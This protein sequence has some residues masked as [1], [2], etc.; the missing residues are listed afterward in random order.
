MSFQTPPSYNINTG[1]P[2][3]NAHL[4]RPP[5]SPAPTIPTP[6]FASAT[7]YFSSTGSRKRS[8]PDSAYSAD[9]RETLGQTPGWLQCPTP[10]DRGYGSASASVYGQGTMM[11]N[12]RYTLA[13]GLDTPGLRATAE[14]EQRDWRFGRDGRSRRDD[15]DAV[16]DSY[17]A[18]P[19]LSG[20]LARERNGVARIPSSPNGESSASW[21]GLAF[22]IV[23]KVFTFGTS[24]VKGFYA[25][26][27]TGYNFKHGPLRSALMGQETC[28][29]PLPGAWH[30]DEF[31]GDFEQD[32]PQIPTAGSGTR[33]PS[34][35]RQTD[36][37]SW[38][39]VG[40][41]S[42]VEQSPRRKASSTVLACNNN[43][44]VRPTASR[45][46][47]RRS[48]APL[49]HRQS[50]YTAYS[51]G[52]PAPVTLAPHE[53][54]ASIAPI[55]IHS[56]P[57]SSGSNPSRAHAVKAVN[58][59]A[60]TSGN[61]SLAY[62]S[63]EAGKLLRRREKQDR[64]ADAAIGDMSRKLAELI[65]QGQQALGTKISVEEGGEDG[66]EVEEG[67]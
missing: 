50:S 14:M 52:S 1:L 13:G 54:R 67:W 40:T 55:R 56:R 27:G 12:E 57:S 32:N 48:L 62:V 36:K 60:H 28:S 59:N 42:D 58:G 2:G 20:P 33:P 65:R 66:E 38:V 41:P 39:M 16:R 45:A 34:K 8:R 21:T 7:D 24:V 9:T 3:R 29:T 6:N 43:L 23:G 46:S 49:P 30:D 26:G 15:G 64:K 22:S 18:R 17:G 61:P 63:P 35:R 4:F 31:L 51:T 19:Q 47:S 44:T 37:D 5:Q 10:D 25:G 53:R 11:V